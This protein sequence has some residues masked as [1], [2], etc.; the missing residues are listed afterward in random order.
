MKNELMRRLE[1][2]FYR[3]TEQYDAN[4][5]AL[6]REKDVDVDEELIQEILYEAKR[7]G[8]F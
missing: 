2:Q 6:F 8:V 3:Y 5:L 4:I 7:R 1:T